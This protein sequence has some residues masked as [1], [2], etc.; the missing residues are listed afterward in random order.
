[1]RQR[2][3]SRKL[4]QHW[5]LYSS[6]RG[7]SGS[8]ALLSSVPVAGWTVS[9]PALPRPAPWP[10]RVPSDFWLGA[11]KCRLV[12]TLVDILS[13]FIRPIPVRALSAVCVLDAHRL[14]LLT[15]LLPKPSSLAVLWLPY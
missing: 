14:P 1:M 6:P 8:A 7:R 5:L 13:H 4:Q 9:F 10:S 12:G 11:R 3:L 15:V 2:A